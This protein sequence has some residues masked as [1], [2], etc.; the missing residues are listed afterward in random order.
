LT[1]DGK[2]T[3]V[4][5]S[6]AGTVHLYVTAQPGVNLEQYVNRNVN[7]YG[8]MTYYGPVKSNYMVVQQVQP[9]QP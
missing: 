5:E 2:P 6:S 4:L 8:P 3:Y 7:L 1:V 9:L